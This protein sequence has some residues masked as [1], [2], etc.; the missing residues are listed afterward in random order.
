MK[1]FL[2]LFTLLSIGSTLFSQEYKSA[3]GLRLGSSL[4]VSYKNFIEPNK[5]IEGVLD[6]DILYRNEMKVE[7]KGLYL[8]HFGLNVDGLSA[9]AGPGVS[10]GI[11]VGD[12]SGYIMSIEG[13]AGFEYKFHNSPIALSFDWNPRLQMIKSAGLKGDGFAITIRYVL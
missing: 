2:V 3:V 4:G 9:F 5:A 13:M 11:Y 12:S 8:F 1:R 6:L 10:A 7:V